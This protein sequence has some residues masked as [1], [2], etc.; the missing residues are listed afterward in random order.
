MTRTKALDVVALMLRDAFGWLRSILSVLIENISACLFVTGTVVL[1]VGVA[2]FSP[3]AANVVLGVLLI[4][5]SVWPYW[6]ARKN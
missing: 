3:A 2:D 5:I 6:A 1:Y 4:A